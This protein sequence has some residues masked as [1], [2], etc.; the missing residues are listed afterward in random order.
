[1]L[2]TGNRRPAIGRN[3]NLLRAAGYVLQERRV[4]E[5]AYDRSGPFGEATKPP[6][7]I[8]DGKLDE[9]F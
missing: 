2:F 4:I 7:L 8:V 9:S 6:R 3:R 5:R 1:V